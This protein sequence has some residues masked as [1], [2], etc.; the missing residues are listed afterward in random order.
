[1]GPRDL[2]GIEEAKILYAF[3]LT[4]AKGSQEDAASTK[5]LVDILLSEVNKSL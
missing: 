5:L 4:P 3:K 1:L 2:E